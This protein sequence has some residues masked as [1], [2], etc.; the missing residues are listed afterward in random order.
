MLVGE[1]LKQHEFAAARQGAAALC[2]DLPSLDPRAQKAIN[3]L[4]ACEE[5]Q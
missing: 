4:K 1:Q 5:G 2:P 3:L